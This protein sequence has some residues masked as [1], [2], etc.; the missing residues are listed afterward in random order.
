MQ[1]AFPDSYT[2]RGGAH[3][4]I[5][6]QN[7]TDTTSLQR[8]VMSISVLKALRSPVGEESA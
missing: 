6:L 1:D 7:V 2:V 5:H 4:S 3:D 8:F